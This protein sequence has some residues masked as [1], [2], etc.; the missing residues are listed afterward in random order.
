MIGHGLRSIAGKMRWAVTKFETG[1]L[2]DDVYGLL[3]TVERMFPH[4][5]TAM[6]IKK[7]AHYLREAGD[8]DTADAILLAAGA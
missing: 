2:Q 8:T 7:T 5:E 6:I 3:E 4:W 1:G